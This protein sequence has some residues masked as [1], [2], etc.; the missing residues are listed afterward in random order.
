MHTFKP[1]KGQAWIDQI[2]NR[3]A[4]A[5]RGGPVRRAKAS[6]KKHASLAS[7]YSAAT[8]RGWVIVE[9]GSDWHFYDAGLSIRRVSGVTPKGLPVLAS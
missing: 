7:T 3:S 4:V 1:L 2:F 8:Y 5:R 9:I 6:I